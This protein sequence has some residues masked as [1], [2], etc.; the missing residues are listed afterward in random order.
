MDEEYEELT[1]GSYNYEDRR[2]EISPSS[3]HTLRDSALTGDPTLPTHSH[4]LVFPSDRDTTK[5]EDITNLEGTDPQ[6]VE[7]KIFWED[8]DVQLAIVPESGMARREHGDLC[9]ILT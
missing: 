9:R 5:L 7:E 6:S 2:G 8:K 1:I 3:L 4:E